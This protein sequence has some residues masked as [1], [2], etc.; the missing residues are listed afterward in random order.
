MNKKLYLLAATLV[1]GGCNGSPSVSADSSQ[2]TDTRTAQSISDSNSQNTAKSDKNYARQELLTGVLI[3]ASKIVKNIEKNYIANHVD[4]CV[5]GD[6]KKICSIG[7]PP[8]IESWFIEMDKEA[9]AYVKMADTE[10][11]VRFS[12]QYRT[13]KRIVQAMEPSVGWPEYSGMSEEMSENKFIRNKVQDL[14]FANLA[15][16]AIARKMQDRFDDPTDLRHSV[17]VALA[18][19]KNSELA[20]LWA[21]SEVMATDELNEQITVDRSTGKGTVWIAGSTEYSGQEN[22]WI[23]KSSGNTILG[24]GYISG[25][26]REYEVASSTELSMRIERGGRMEE[27]STNNQG[28]KAEVTAK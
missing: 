18:S 26:K 11:G 3:A 19:Y 20:E 22:G 14:Q 8:S 5:S 28:V 12:I 4:G 21:S 24:S 2:N 17:C 27:G 1:F 15:L 25:T 23:V 7:I 13:L 6:L 16:D 10:A 9:S